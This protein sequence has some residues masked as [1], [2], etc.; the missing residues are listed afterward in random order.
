MP[1]KSTIE[2][3]I[4]ALVIIL[5]VIIVVLVIISPLSFTD[6]KSVYQGF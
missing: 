2:F 6:V 3:F 1:P 5:S 4:Y